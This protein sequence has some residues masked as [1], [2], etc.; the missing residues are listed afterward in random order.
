M[1]GALGYL[2]GMTKCLLC[3]REH[4]PM[5]VSFGIYGSIGICPGHPMKLKGTVRTRTKADGKTPRIV[6]NG[7]IGRAQGR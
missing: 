7:N 6:A 5:S 1:A 4:E 2:R 3:N